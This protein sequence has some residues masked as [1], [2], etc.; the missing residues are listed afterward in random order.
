MR[1]NRR[2]Y[3]NYSIIFT[4]EQLRKIARYDLDFFHDLVNSAQKLV[5]RLDEQPR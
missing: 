3:G 2:N 5:K 4:D 1:I